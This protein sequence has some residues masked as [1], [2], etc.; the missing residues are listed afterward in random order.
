MTVSGICTFATFITFP[1]YY[2]AL[3]H[4]SNVKDLASE[5]Q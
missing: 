5:K 2:G 4:E 1:H 3:Q